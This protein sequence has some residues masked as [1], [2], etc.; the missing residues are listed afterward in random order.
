M[1]TAL[2]FA[3]D[4]SY[5]K[6]EEEMREAL[7]DFPRRAIPRW[8]SAEKCNVVLERDSILPRFPCLG[9][10]RRNAIPQRMRRWP[11]ASLWRTHS[12]RRVDRYMYEA[13]VIIQQGFPAYFLIVQEYIRWARENGIA[14][15]PASS[16]PQ[17]LFVRMPWA[18]PT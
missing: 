13:G 17:A 5:M 6:T 3:N 12:E 2:S 8:E 10:H 7:R 18:L 1:R 14:V 11:E 15:G 4:R 9:I 16:R